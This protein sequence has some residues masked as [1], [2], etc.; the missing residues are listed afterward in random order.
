MRPRRGADAGFSLVEVLVAMGVFSVL[1]TVVLG[2]V[3][4]TAGVAAT[5]DRRVVA[6]GLADRQLESARSQRAVDIVDGGTTRVETVGNVTYIVKQTA[7]YV[8]ADATTSV[9]TATGSSLA[10]KLV[11]VTVSWPDMGRVKPVRADTLRAVGIGD[12]GLDAATGSVALAVVGADGAA[13]AD[14]PVTLTPGGLTLTTGQDGCVVFTGLAPAT[15]TA[16]ADVSGY[17]GTANTQLASL[18]SLGVT[19]GGIARGTLTYDTARA[20]TLATSGPAGFQAPAGI[21]PVLRNTFV[22]ET[23]YPACSAAAQGCVTGLPGQAQHL[24]P[25]VYDVWAGTCSDARTSTGVPAVID[26]RPASAGSTV[27]LPLAPALVDVR[28]LLNTSLGAIGITA[29]H[30]AEA[31]GLGQRCVTGESYT[32]PVSVIGG[33]GVLLPAGTWTFSAAGGL[34]PVT[35]TLTTGSTTNVVLSVPV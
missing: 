12:D 2:L 21:R 11:T 22:A 13:L 5:N 29:T 4:R 24:F 30:A 1:V 32:L 33:V 7:S 31:T 35:V 26:L 20:V 14:I 28:G 3:V 10:Y 25:A 16:T 17:V 27:T 6:A 9:C 8:P 18:A 23:T 34:L 15:Y 19:A